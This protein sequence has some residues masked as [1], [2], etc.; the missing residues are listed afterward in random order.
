MLEILT[1]ATIGSCA[2]SICAVPRP[3]PARF[4]IA[5][6][7]ATTRQEIGPGNRT[8]RTTNLSNASQSQTDII[9]RNIATT[10]VTI[11][12]IIFYLGLHLAPVI[13]I[14]LLIATLL[15]LAVFQFI[16]HNRANRHCLSDQALAE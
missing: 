4:V 6:N 8:L 13:T 12:L 7:G 9:H 1:L 16:I 10:A 2:P 5:S 11:C 3:Q 14:L 15:I